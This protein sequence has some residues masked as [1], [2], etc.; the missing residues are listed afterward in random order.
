MEKV[1]SLSHW[2]WLRSVFVGLVTASVADRRG[3]LWRYGR[4]KLP[5]LPFPRRGGRGDG[6]VAGD[7]GLEPVEPDVGR[8]HRDRRPTVEFGPG[9]QGDVAGR[10]PGRR[11]PSARRRRPR[12]GPT[13]ELPSA[14]PASAGRGRRCRP[15]A[16]TVEAPHGDGARHRGPPGPRHRA[17]RAGDVQQAAVASAGEANAQRLRDLTEGAEPRARPARRRPG[18]D[19]QLRTGLRADPQPRDSSRRPRASAVTTSART[20]RPSSSSSGVDD[21]RREQADHVA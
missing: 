2:R 15:G 12:G 11:A 13:A 10:G 7:G 4:R 21:Q 6:A 18:L 9:G 20:S 16:A 17:C 19:A 3:L 1:R 5:G 8:S 14:V